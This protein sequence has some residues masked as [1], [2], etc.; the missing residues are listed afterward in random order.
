ME[1]RGVV[2]LASRGRP[3][4]HLCFR[5]DAVSVLEQNLRFRLLLRRTVNSAHLHL[6]GPFS[7][8]EK[9]RMRTRFTAACT[10]PG[11]R[12]EGEG[13][14]QYAVFSGRISN[15]SAVRLSA[16]CPISARQEYLS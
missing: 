1:R 12:P 6:R 8:R 15:L 5:E 13:E 4:L 7:P 3:F 10:H 9:D 16:R 14:K 11:P 2:G